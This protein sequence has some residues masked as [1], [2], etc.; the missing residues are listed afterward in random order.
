MLQNNVNSTE[1]AT[2]FTYGK[3]MY[4]MNIYF[5]V[6]LLSSQAPG[7]SQGQSSHSDCSHPSPVRPHNESSVWRPMTA[8]LPQ[9]TTDTTDRTRQQTF[10]IQTNSIPHNPHKEM[11]NRRQKRGSFEAREEWRREPLHRELFTQTESKF[12]H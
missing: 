2:E 6:D 9:E 7:V 12:C 4:N 10:N 8:A 3:R 1:Y 11:E 5:S